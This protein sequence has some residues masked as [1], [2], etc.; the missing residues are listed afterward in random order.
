MKSVKKQVKRMKKMTVRDLVTTLA[1]FYWSM[2]LRVLYVVFSVA[3]GF[4]RITYKSLMGG[5]L[6]NGGSAMKAR[7]TVSSSCVVYR[8]CMLYSTSWTF[9]SVSDLNATPPGVR[10][11]GQPA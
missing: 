4:C 9:L 11:A 7:C 10:A 1:S 6:L 3:R 8:P 2:L 5:S